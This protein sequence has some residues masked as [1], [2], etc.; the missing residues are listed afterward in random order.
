MRDVTEQQADA[1]PTPDPIAI[2]RRINE[3]HEDIA[4][5]VFRQRS[6]VGWPRARVS[7]E[8]ITC[9]PYEPR[10]GCVW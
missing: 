10:F 5:G 7:T 3:M 1:H 9:A 4:L 2:Q 8:V 6:Q